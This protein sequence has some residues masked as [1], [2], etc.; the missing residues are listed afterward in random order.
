MLIFNLDITILF[1]QHQG[2]LEFGLVGDDG[3]LHLLEVDQPLL[4]QTLLVISRVILLHLL[5]GL[6]KV[7]VVDLQETER[8]GISDS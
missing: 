5:A 3:E 6:E 2:A 7:D 1:A 8:V 4:Q